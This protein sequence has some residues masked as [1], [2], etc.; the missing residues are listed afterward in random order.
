M[1]L[2]LKL[3]KKKVRIK[4][5]ISRQVHGLHCLS[6]GVCGRADR[7][8]SLVLSQ[9]LAT[10]KYSQSLII[11]RCVTPVPHSSAGCALRDIC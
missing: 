5:Q 7:A 10:V 4:L 9:I 1:L 3:K 8:G 11:T 2:H 6:T